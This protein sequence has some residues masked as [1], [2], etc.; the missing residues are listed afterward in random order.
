[1]HF[2]RHHIVMQRIGKSPPMGC[3]VILLLA[4]WVG[5]VGCVDL[6]RRGSVEKGLY[7]D[8]TLWAVDSLED[9]H[10]AVRD[11]V[12]SHVAAVVHREMAE[13]L[14]HGICARG[15][16][17]LRWWYA[18]KSG[19]PCDPLKDFPDCA[20]RPNSVDCVWGKK[21]EQRWIRSIEGSYFQRL[22]VDALDTE[23]H[24]DAEGEPKP[25]CENF[26]LR[27]QPVVA[28]AAALLVRA[29]EKG[30]VLFATAAHVF[31][32]DNGQ[33]SAERCRN[34]SF[35]LG[36]TAKFRPSRVRVEP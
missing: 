11:F 24:P 6:S 12:K 28:R 33:W 34:T 3:H 17:G 16:A 10:P 14:T 26:P 4:A 1:M 25:L 27:S 5:V 18:K 20:L 22:N 36:L 15:V 9:E 30:V 32:D 23:E 29:P 21:G 13:W 19:Q 8:N 35:V 2:T 7:E 31:D